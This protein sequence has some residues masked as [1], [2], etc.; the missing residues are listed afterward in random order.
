M[1]AAGLFLGVI[2]GQ[3]FDFA[4]IS[5][6]GSISFVQDLTK[7]LLIVE[8]DQASQTNNPYDQIDIMTFSELEIALEASSATEL[9]TL[10]VMTPRVYEVAI[11][12]Q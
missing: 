8:S 2:S 10:D 1:V 4:Q 5:N 7:D 3:L 9:Y 6:L 11:N 12:T